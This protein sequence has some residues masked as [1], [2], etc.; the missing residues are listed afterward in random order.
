MVDMMTEETRTC[1][2]VDAKAKPPSALDQ[3]F[4]DPRA[5]LQLIDDLTRADADKLHKMTA[6]QKA[7]T[8]ASALVAI[9]TVARG[10][11]EQPAPKPEPVKVWACTIN[12]KYGDSVQ[13]F[14]T[15]AAC[16]ETLRAYM[17][18]RW[19]E[20]EMGEMPDDLAEACGIFNEYR[21]DAT[22]EVEQLEVK[23]AAT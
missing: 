17:R 14:T 3:I 23:E 13:L 1:A 22:M 21:E 18:E 6:T 5:A 12:D 16:D 19:N 7:R 10:A 9:S 20:S 4:A 8:L 11:L 15:E 2:I